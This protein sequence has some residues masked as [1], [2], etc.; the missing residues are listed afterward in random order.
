MGLYPSVEGHLVYPWYAK[1]G[2][3][4]P[5]ILG[6]DAVVLVD[7][8]VRCGTVQS[9][10]VFRRTDRYWSLCNLVGAPGWSAFSVSESI[11]NTV[12]QHGR[13]AAAAG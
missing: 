3:T 2:E 10:A 8:G 12:S 7:Y 13:V 6:A 9:G 4:H 5:L 11:T 1:A